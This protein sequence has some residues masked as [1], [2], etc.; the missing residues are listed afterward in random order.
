MGMQFDIDRLHRLA[1]GQAGI[2]T[3]AQLVLLGMTDSMLRRWVASGRLIK[4]HP[5][6]YAV[7]YLPGTR[8]SALW[9]AVLYAGPGAMLSHLTAAQ[10]AGLIKYAPETIHVSTPR[11]I[12]SLAGVE[13]HSRRRLDRIG[14]D[15]VPLSSTADILRDLAAVRP[16]LLG[17]ALAQLDFQQGLD[18]DLILAAARRRP[19]LQDA[20]A[21]YDP[22]TARLNG[23]F[24]IDF[25]AFCVEQHI[26]PL[27]VPNVELEPRLTVDALWRDHGLAV[28]L[29]GGDN[30]RSDAQLLRDADRDLRCRELGISVIRYRRAQLRRN[31]TAV[32]HDLRRALAVAGLTAATS[33]VS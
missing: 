15:G 9:A 3:R 32:A 2:V 22:Q 8:E 20:L 4:V 6:V 23:P 7:G 26:E 28:E 27:P 17:R 5:G 25:Y 13:V 1:A 29:D 19:V 11:K 31:P 14:G 16:D 12:A 30:H 18:R 10:Y 33:R 24:E 21:T